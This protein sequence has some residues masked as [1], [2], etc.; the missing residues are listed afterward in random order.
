MA[1]IS[2]AIDPFG[3]LA[4]V[5]RAVCMLPAPRSAGGRSALPT[6]N[7]AGRFPREFYLETVAAFALDRDPTRG[8]LGT[9]VRDCLSK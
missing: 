5:Q 6:R 2:A 4:H 3:P 7:A 8:V 1:Q 9:S